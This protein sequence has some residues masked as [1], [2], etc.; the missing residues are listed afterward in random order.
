MK[1]RMLLTVAVTLTVVATVMLP[2]CGGGEGPPPYFNDVVA[3]SEATATPPPGGW[4][5]LGGEATISV[6][7]TS[8]AGIESVHANISSTSYYKRISLAMTAG[9]TYQNVVT[10]RPNSARTALRYTVIII[11][12]DHANNMKVVSITFD[13]PQSDANQ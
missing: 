10:I 12:K 4:T 6:K 1:C 7:A 5:S 2:G 13:I 11:A 9:D 8:P 3:L